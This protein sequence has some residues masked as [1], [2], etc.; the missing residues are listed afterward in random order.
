MS[1]IP[2]GLKSYLRAP[3]AAIVWVMETYS[4]NRERL[5]VFMAQPR[6]AR[7]FKM[8]IVV[9]ALA[10]IVIALMANEEQ[11]QRLTDALKGFWSE[12]QSLSEER[13]AL[14]ESKEVAR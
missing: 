1:G 13:K 5:R 4:K 8:A 3:F 10:W 7:I 14:Q 2:E 6:T 11:G 9:T 12:T